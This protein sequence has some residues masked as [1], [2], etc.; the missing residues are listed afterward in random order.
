MGFKLPKNKSVLFGID[1]EMSTHSRP[2]IYKELEGGI[3]AEANR[4]GTI[5]LDP[6][7]PDEMKEEVVAHEDEH[8]FQMGSGRLGYNKNEVTWK[9]TTR[10]HMQTFSRETMSEGLESLPWEKEAY[11]VSDKIKKT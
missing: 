6:S 7:V 2:V 11:N 9:P 1:E 5:F 3:K 8:L 4:D 10:S